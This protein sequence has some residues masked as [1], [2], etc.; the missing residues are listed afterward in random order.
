MHILE[1]ISHEKIHPANPTLLGLCGVDCFEELDILVQPDHEAQSNMDTDRE[2][3]LHLA[4]GEAKPMLR[5]YSWKPYSVSLGA[6]QRESDID[7]AACERLGIAVVRRPTGGR[8]IFH[9]NELTYSLVL[10]LATT[11]EPKRTAH[12][13]YR[14]VHIL[15]LQA[16]QSL[17][18]EGLDFEKKQ[19]DFRSLYR[20]GSVAMPCF[21]SSARYE[22]L[23][24]GRK[25]VGS[26]QKLYG[27]V[28]LQHGSVLLGAGH[29][30]LAEVL[31]ISND[32]ERSEVQR[33]ILSHSAIL[34]EACGR[35]ISFEE[36]ARAILRVFVPPSGTE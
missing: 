18:A 25:V 29:E 10:P 2:R 26:A 16:L 34:A 8:A 6:H 32:A 1:Q 9:A 14:D 36:C 13:I 3:A 35:E 23:F 12:D 28:V 31:N 24:D 17:G 15:L 27:N 11:L 5:L 21:A 30:R 4:S 19:P 33:M 20:S 7:F 22:L